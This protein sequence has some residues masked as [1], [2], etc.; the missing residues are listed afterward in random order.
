MK[1]IKGSITAPEGF[2]ASA[3]QSGIK[4]NKLDL[5]LIVSKT[6][7]VAAG[8]FTKNVV[9]AA[10]VVLSRQRLKRGRAQA[11]I[12]NSGNANCLN[13]D[14]GLKDALEITQIAAGLTGVDKKDVLVASTGVIGKPLAADKIKEAI[15]RLVKGLNRNGG[16][17]AARAIMTTDIY[18]KEI[19]V[20]VDIRGKTV[21]IGGIAKGSGMICPDM[22]TMLCFITTDANIALD[23]LKRSL[24][25]AS[26]DSFNAITIDGDMSTNDTV[27]IL[28]NGLA[29]NPRIRYDT[30]D[31]R[32][33]SEALSYVTGC[34]A[35]EIAMDG[36][37]ASKFIEIEVN[38][39]KN[40]NDARRVAKEIANSNL[41]K[42]AIA[43][44]DPNVGRIAS[45]A[46]AAKVKF[47]ESALDV[48]L[49]GIKII[50]DGKTDY[51]LRGR[52][53]NL[54]K[55]KDVKIEVDLKCGVSC[56]TVWTCDL[57]EGYIKIN[58]RYN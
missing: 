1:I 48:S 8:V 51:G 10:P 24:K 13:G 31:Y 57:T 44:E 56:A 9:Q 32:K 5:A 39:A 49:C 33:F 40:K 27:F 6:P 4:E 16:V 29:A 12:A 55:K 42:T 36:E 50:R 52:I 26:E 38:G 2:V 3:V 47:K 37:G 22:A 23:A 25:E 20:T 41:V 7:C 46:G 17:L 18:P 19:A 43:G 11:I 34:L 21:K 28:A 15:P 45:A 53:K 30:D 14:K 58:A 54:L 35:K